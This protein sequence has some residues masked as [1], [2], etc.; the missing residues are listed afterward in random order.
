MAIKVDLEK[1]YDR[2]DWR[3]LEK[4]LKAVGFGRELSDVILFCIRSTRLSI[5]W[6]G[7]KLDSFALE[8]GLRQ[9]D[10]L[11][12]YLFVLCMELLG[13]A[14][15]KQLMKGGGCQLTH[16]EAGLIYLIFFLRMTLFFLEMHL[17]SKQV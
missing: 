14:I 15:T 5:I 10:P 3:F 17:L 7:S 8:W 2:A 6:N 16:L 1:A 4:V 12:S 9:G 13:Q 11:S